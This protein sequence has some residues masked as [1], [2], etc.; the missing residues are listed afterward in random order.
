[1]IESIQIHFASPSTIREWATRRLSDGT[2]FLGQVKTSDTI[3]YRTF[4][5]ERDGLF[6]EEI[7]GTKQA[8]RHWIG[9]IFLQYPVTHIWF[10]KSSYLSL[11]LNRPKKEL[12][13]LAYCYAFLDTR[14]SC[15]T[16]SEAIRFLIQNRNVA[17]ESAR[18]RLTNS[19]WE[20]RRIRRLRLL[21]Y[22]LQLKAEWMVLSILPILPPDLR[23]IVQLDGG[24]F[25]S[26]DL[27][28]LYRLVINRNKRCLDAKQAMAP[29]LIRTANKRLLQDAVDALLDTRK[30]PRVRPLRS[31][32]DM[33]KGKQGRFRQNLLGKRV[34][35]SG[36]S[37]IVVGPNLKI[38]ECGLPREM[39]LELFQPFVIREL[40]QKV[41]TIRAAKALIN[42]KDKTVWSIL[43]DV[44]YHHPVLLNR[45]PTLHR[46]SMQAFEPRLVE[47]KAIYLHPLVCPAFNADFD[48]DQMAV[49]VPL[50]AE[51]QQEAR[52]LMLASENLLSPATGQPIT[53][54]SQDMVLGLYYLTAEKPG[55]K[56]EY[57]VPIYNW[58]QAYLQN[59]ISLH[60]WIWVPT[61][62]KIEDPIEFR[63]CSL[64]GIQRISPNSFSLLNK[65]YKITTIGR[66]IFHEIIDKIQNT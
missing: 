27:N 47:G 62:N 28:D 11:F 1:M 54:P 32:S 5:P 36:R 53:V 7:F 6:C 45:A 16:G 30:R 21:H 3:N 57:S 55:S 23:P 29:D 40:L 8:R 39:A 61:E 10:R 20:N 33:L 50:S 22:S 19:K 37:V 49:H 13:S 35:Y 60:S 51:S 44:I 4:K 52:Q 24:Q 26:S 15:N 14:D 64:G 46:L 58:K 25:A 59:E 63:I 18:I 31:L 65:H 38:F 2:F 66:L 48:G 43:E 9:C 41:P 42:N 34:D 12:E 56:A 17:R